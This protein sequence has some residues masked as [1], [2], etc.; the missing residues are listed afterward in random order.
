MEARREKRAVYMLMAFIDAH[1]R[2]QQRIHSY[3]GDDDRNLSLTPE[4]ARVKAESAAV[5][6]DL[7]T[8]AAF[9]PFKHHTMKC[10]FSFDS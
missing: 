2:A 1:T 8:L 9:R 3:L 10:T 5:V 7:A 6:S 4:E